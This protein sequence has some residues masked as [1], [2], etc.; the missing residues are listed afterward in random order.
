M[1]GYKVD[2]LF[3]IKTNQHIYSTFQFAHVHAENIT[4]FRVNGIDIELEAAKT[5]DIMNEIK[6]TL[7]MF[8]N[9]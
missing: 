4:A 1:T 9:C 8:F 2:E 7:I 5:T 3:T 6:G